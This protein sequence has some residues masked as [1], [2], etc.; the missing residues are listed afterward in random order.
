MKHTA[1]KEYEARKAGMIAGIVLAFLIPIACIAYWSRRY[2]VNKRKQAEY[3][4]RN[5]RKW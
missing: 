1:E 2:V 5:P 4:F 3:D